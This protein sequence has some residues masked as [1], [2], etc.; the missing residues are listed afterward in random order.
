MMYSFV[1]VQI[2]IG[3]LR[4]HTALSIP[5]FIYIAN[6]GIARYV[7]EPTKYSHIFL[8]QNT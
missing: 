5:P 4:I 1:Y 3:S 8:Q 6:V 2:N 7:C